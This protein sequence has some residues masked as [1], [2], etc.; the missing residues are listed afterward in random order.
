MAVLAIPARPRLAGGTP[1]RLSL[2]S[3]LRVGPGA[4]VE[5]RRAWGVVARDRGRRAEAHH[6]LARRVAAVAARATAHQPLLR[7]R[8][9]RGGDPDGCS[10]VGGRAPRG[11]DGR[12]R[13]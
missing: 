11:A 8:V 4:D 5:S 3:V 9:E 10:P 7:G 13:L 12:C 1:G 2:S 6:A